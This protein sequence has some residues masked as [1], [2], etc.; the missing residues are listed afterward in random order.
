VQIT[1]D[2]F[3]CNVVAAPAGFVESIE[4]LKSRPPHEGATYLE[5]CRVLVV[6]NSL[7]IAMDAP[8][9]AQIIFQEK[10]AELYNGTKPDFLTKVIT[11]NGKMLVFYK[12]NGCGCSSRLRSWNPFKTLMSTKG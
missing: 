11:V 6:D 1:L 8:E 5:V 3:P 10:I 2:L 9:G 4:D 7:V 12:D